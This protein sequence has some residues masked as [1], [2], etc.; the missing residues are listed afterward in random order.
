MHVPSS[1]GCRD[2]VCPCLPH[3]ESSPGQPAFSE[4]EKLPYALHFA[5]WAP[6]MEQG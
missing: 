1:W 2:L 4:A 3:K 6:E 5:L